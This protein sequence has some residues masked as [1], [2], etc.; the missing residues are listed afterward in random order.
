MSDLRV[1]D[2][3]FAFEAGVCLEH[4][5]RCL[6]RQIHLTA[7]CHSSIYVH[8]SHQH[9]ASIIIIITNFDDTVDNSEKKE[10]DDSIDFSSNFRHMPRSQ[11]DLCHKPIVHYGPP[12]YLFLVVGLTSRFI[13]SYFYKFT[14]RNYHKMII[15]PARLLCFSP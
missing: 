5:A 2:G 8:L 10:T 13:F 15:T 12:I 11:I 14:G 6:E 7:D 4:F 1:V 9:P 3:D